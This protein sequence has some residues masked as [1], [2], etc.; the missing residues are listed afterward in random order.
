MYFVLTEAIQR[1]FILELRRYWQYHPKLRHIVQH[2]QG[3]Y[4]FRERPQEGIILKNSAGNQ[5]RL[6]ADN[7]QG[8]VLSHA[9]LARVENFPG[10]AMEWVRED[11][12]AIQRNRG[13]FPT[14]PGVYFVEI[15][16]V[17][18]DMSTFTFYIDPLLD[19]QDETLRMINPT[20]GQVAA[21]RFLDGTPRVFQMPG[22]VQL[23]E[24]VNYAT[25]PE[26]GSI[27]LFAPLPDNDFLSVDYRWPAYT[28]D[29]SPAIRPLDASGKVQYWTGMPNRAL[30]EPLPGIVMAFGR[31]IE[32][33]DRMAIVVARNRQIS[34]MEFGGRWDLSIDFDVMARDVHVQREILDQTVMYIQGVLRSRLA[35]EGMEIETVNLGG[36]SEEIYD[37]VADDYFYNASFSVQ[38]QTDW[39]L[40][41][42]VVSEVQR[43][44]A[45]TN[46]QIG[47][48]AGLT[49]EEA[50]GFT[51]NLNVVENFPQAVESF[52]LGLRSFRDPF[53]KGRSRTF[54]LIR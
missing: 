7:F 34:A 17:A 33:G 13:V 29:E 18:D 1:R 4:S 49:P 8:T 53:Y 37:N 35:T 24:G 36:E 11:A 27:Q 40:Q 5:V 32:V 14:A 38:V 50:A 26:N 21:G 39:A 3:K 41:V 42:P 15:V 47:E 46:A 45:L 31:R 30:V 20:L 10:V 43:V 2:I 19:V 6:A 25:D 52:G 44:E 9:S 23:V 51:N 12:L 48:L 16:D 22:N 28:S 54:E